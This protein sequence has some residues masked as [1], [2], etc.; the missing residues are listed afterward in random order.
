MKKFL[1]SLG[2]AS[3][4]V[5][6]A[7]WWSHRDETAQA[8]NLVQQSTE[9]M[10]PAVP[11]GVQTKA[12]SRTATRTVSALG[13]VE[14]LQ[15]TTLRA[16][17]SGFVTQLPIALGQSL[18]AGA[19]VAV[20][21]DTTGSLDAQNGFKSSAYQKSQLDESIARK[22]YDQAKKTY[23]SAKTS[24]NKTDREV[25]RL[26]KEKAL[27]DAIAAADTRTVRAPFAGVVAEKFVDTGAGVSAGDAIATVVYGQATV[28]R[29]FVDQNDAVKIT[30]KQE[31]VFGLPDGTEYAFTVLR[32]APVADA[33]TRKVLIEAAI[34][35]NVVNIGI[36]TIGTVRITFTERAST[37]D[38][39]LMPIEAVTTGQ[40]ESFIFIEENGRAKRQ[41][42]L[43]KKI[44]GDW[45]EVVWDGAE[46]T[47]LIMRGA[48]QVT[49]GV[50]VSVQ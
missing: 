20:I 22:E 13:T 41:A 1:W 24:A 19:T 14:A 36:G 31:G 45:A 21:D 27:I 3:I 12:A 25:A 43:V 28:L 26:N 2:V 7:V 37:P 10:A 33:T 11:V 4:V 6:G 35:K 38:A 23:K 47:R 32:R 18:G 8:Q 46:E 49:D 29:F 48:K 50:Q 16:G 34:S 5:G 30:P 15:S 9:Q 42:V 40:N 17:V 39:V 44:R